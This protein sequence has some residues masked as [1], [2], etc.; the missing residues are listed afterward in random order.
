[1]L[2]V[3]EVQSLKYG[4]AKEVPRHFKFIS[5]FKEKVSEDRKCL[6][7]SILSLVLLTLLQTLNRACRLLVKH[8]LN[9]AD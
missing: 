6:N 1:M 3:V 9:Q 5:Y 4:T 7:H 2:P 8:V